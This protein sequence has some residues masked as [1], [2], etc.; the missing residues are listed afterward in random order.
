MVDFWD[1]KYLLY[2]HELPAPLVVRVTF[3]HLLDLLYEL[4][5]TLCKKLYKLLENKRVS[6]KE[7]QEKLL[8]ELKGAH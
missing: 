7:N 4:V 2:I 6:L 1:L 3:Q 5:F 8:G